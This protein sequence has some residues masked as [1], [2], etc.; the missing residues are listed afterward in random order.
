MNVAADLD[1]QALRLIEGF[2][3]FFSGGNHLVE[4][5]VLQGNALGVV[6][7]RIGVFDDQR[8]ADSQDRDVRLET[9]ALVVDIDVGLGRCFIF[10]G[11]R[12]FF[13]AQV[14]ERRLSVRRWDQLRAIR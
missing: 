3:D 10:G 4:L 6:R 13:G 9:A 2:A 7:D 1:R 11:H 12:H 5:G 14:D 8:L